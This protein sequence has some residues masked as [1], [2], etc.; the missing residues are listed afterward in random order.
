MG[1]LTD[2]EQL[3]KRYADARADVAR[4]VHA[5]E[6]ETRKARQRYLAPIKAAVA[7]AHDAQGA[8]KGALETAPELF[9]RPR[10]VTFHGIRVGYMKGKGG[11]T[12][13]DDAKV[14]SLILKHYPADQAE[15]LIKTTRKPVKSALEQ[16]SAA[17][18]K[19]LGVRVEE[20]GDVVFVKPQDA[21]VEKLVDALLKG[22]DEAEAA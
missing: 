22:S 3:T 9:V 6:D 16:L 10:T 1:T 13:D 7:T 18:L 14:V 12:W 15:V 5:L 20:S 2:I 8:L 21:E 17:D 4:L 11:L 19:K